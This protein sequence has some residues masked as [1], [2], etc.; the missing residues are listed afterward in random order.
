[1]IQHLIA[2]ARERPTSPPTEEARS[3]QDRESGDPRE[4]AFETMTIA[5]IQY[6]QRGPAGKPCAAAA[7]S[8]PRDEGIGKEEAEVER[9]EMTVQHF[10]KS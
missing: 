1:M 9:V 5:R 10:G 7:T 3:Q 6:R 8:S 4:A 2:W